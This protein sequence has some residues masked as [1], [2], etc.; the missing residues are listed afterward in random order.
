[1]EKNMFRKGLV[2]VLIVMY[3]G[4][5]VI[6]SIG[7]SVIEKKSNHPISDSNTWYVGG[8]EES[9]YTTIQD[10]IDN[11][12]NGDTVFV[13]DDSSPYYET[14]TINK[15]ISLIG[16]D[17]D[18]AIIDGS[19]SGDVI[20]VSADRVNI[21][22]FT[23]QNSQ[24]GYHEAIII[25]SSFNTINDNI[26]TANNGSGIFCAGGFFGPACCNVISGNIISSNKKYGIYIVDSSNNTINGNN[27]ISNNFDG[28]YFSNSIS[29]AITGNY[30]LNNGNGINIYDSNS[31]TITG[32]NIISNNYNGLFLSG[33]SSN[34]ITSNNIISNTYD[35]I[36]L[37]DSN[38]NTITG[39]NI[40]NN[41][42]GIYLYGSDFNKIQC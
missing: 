10:A 15:S 27:I 4:T 1:M 28:I 21:S 5:G 26:I 18:T 22:G 16:E 34:T 17:K 39:N 3:V 11:S 25:S 9:N 31:N 40:S 13:F 12:S 30:I 37:Y 33:S 36:Y 35:G 20:K 7:G 32:N 23:I 8:T 38:S 41:N 42:N 19:D 14:I 2:L 24:S 29:N 6:P